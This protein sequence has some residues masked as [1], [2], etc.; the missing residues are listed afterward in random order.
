[1]SITA[2]LE[3]VLIARSFPTITLWNRLEGRPRAD[4]FDR[5]L[6]AEVR[7]ALWMTTRQWQLGELRGDDAASPIEIKIQMAQTRI[8]KYRPNGFA[9]ESFNDNIPLEANVERR[10]VPM[11]VL[12]RAISLDIRLLLG[13]QWLKMIGASTTT[14]GEYRTKYPVTAPDP[15][16]NRDALYCAHPEAWSSVA[17]VAGRA[18]DGF[19]LIEYLAE[20]ASHH[21]ADGIPSLAGSPLDLVGIVNRFREW[22][23]SLIYQPAG[24]DAWL[25]ERLEYQFACSAPEGT[26]EKVYLA[27]EYFHGHL[28]WYNLDIDPTTTVLGDPVPPMPNPAKNGV[29][30]PTPLTFDGIPNTRWW[31]FEDSRTNFGEIRPDTTDLAKL[32]LIEFGLTC[33]N[34]WFLVPYTVPSGSVVRIRGMA[35]TDVFGDRTWVEAAGR[36]PDDDWQRWAM[37]LNSIKGHGQQI[38]DTS[39]LLLPSAPAVQQGRALEEVMLVRDEIAN[40]VWGIEKTIALPNGEPKAGAEAARE[41]KAFFER[42]AIPAMLPPLIEN[43]AKIRYDAMNTVPENWIPFIPVHVPGDNRETQLQRAA[44]LRIVEG[45]PEVKVRPRTSLMRAGLDVSIPVGYFLHEEEVLRAGV[46]V[47]QRYQRTR[48]RDGRAWVWLGVQK[49]TGR[50]EATSGLAFDRLLDIEPR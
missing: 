26:A 2:N 17:A 29:V 33:A 16:D 27:E 31:T 30:I 49:Q 47:T 24:E 9:V 3:E 18:M 46:I 35:V 7:D 22:F 44:M 12:G 21:P 6:K 15:N 13:R 5:A 41:T 8:R 45:L 10:T 19:K 28:D 50:G 20:N 34:D 38:A 40:M 32:L 36:G 25:P 43:D 11:K 23:A 37:F 14:R 39:L 4:R 48:W 42:K 1:M